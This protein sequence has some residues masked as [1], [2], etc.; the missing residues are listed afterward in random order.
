MMLNR[1]RLYQ[2]ALCLCLSFA[3]Q[4]HADVRDNYPP[5]AE[6]AQGTVS[7]ILVD[8]LKLFRGIPYARRP[9]GT[10]RWKAPEPPD[11]W[12]GFRDASAF[13]PSC[14]Q[15]PLRPD[16]IY[17]DEPVSMSE[18]C[19]TL[20]IWAPAEAARAPVIVWIFGGAL[21]RGQSASPLY[22][23]ATYAHRG[24]V[25]V[26]INY[27]LGVLGWLAH[28]ALSAESPEQVS[29]NYGLLDQIQ[30]L[31]WVQENIAAFGGDPDNVTIMGESA[32][33]LSVAYLLTSPRARGLFHKAIAESPNIRP[34]PMLDRS[35]YGLPS[36]E[37]TGVA[38]ATRVGA[39][40]LAD[41]RAMDAADLTQ[42]SV[43]ARFW[44][45][46]TVDGKVLP[47]QLVDIF[48]AGQQA[49]VPLLA[50][51]NSGEIRSQR[52]FLPPAPASAALYEEEITH[53]Y[54]DLA[55]AFLK[56]YPSTD[57]PGSMLATVRDA[58]YGWAA[59]RMVRLQTEAGQPAFLYIFDRCYPAAA[60]QDLCAFH[61]SELPFVFGHVGHEAWL[62]PNWPRPDSNEDKSL[63]DAMIGYWVGFAKSGIPAQAG[64]PQ[65]RAY[66]D[67]EDYMR[68]GD[69]AVPSKNPV[70]GMFELQE[71]VVA[72]RRHAEQPWFINV[73]VASP[74]IPDAANTDTGHGQ[75]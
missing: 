58:I 16:S 46:G 63:S 2:L 3:S 49:K 45:Q 74:V 5:T 37:E 23:G 9:V 64:L 69:E 53:R 35:I 41:L 52:V 21:Q 55:P 20:N 29:G 66:S 56:V 1:F 31:R 6:T 48:D 18:D 34:F 51:F 50:G 28:P 57:V 39:A 68:F 22:D 19:L 62:P 40:D 38:V 26:S 71:D 25:F 73:G 75:Q 60:R 15:P 43:T 61:A 47:M 33:A 54:R 4:V 72:R 12:A 17:A 67:G 59:E 14:V 70:P 42:A 24:I 27:R 13:G 44:P 10:S 8:G 36:A 7:G 11:T 65:W 30:A 32:G